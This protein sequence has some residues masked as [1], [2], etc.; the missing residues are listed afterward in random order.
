MSMTDTTPPTEAQRYGRSQTPE[1]PR[2]V[3]LPEPA[4]I[5]VLLNQMDPVFNDTATYNIPADQSFSPYSN[6]NA[7]EVSNEEHDAVQDF[8]RGAEAESALAQNPLA[9]VV[10]QAQHDVE[11]ADVEQADA[12]NAQNA[13]Q[14]PLVPSSIGPIIADLV[15]SHA[16]SVPQ[17]GPADTLSSSS[18]HAAAS[19]AT[20]GS[21]DELS[22]PSQACGSNPSTVPQS[23]DVKDA[24]VDYSSLL[25]SLAKTM[26]K[27]APAGTTITT[28]SATVTDTD[29]AASTQASASGLPPKPHTKPPLSQAGHSP[30]AHPDN[31]QLE[32]ARAEPS[33]SSPK[34][35]VN[36][37]IAVQQQTQAP[38]PSATVPTPTYTQVSR[39][40]SSVPA[41]LDALLSSQN[42]G[43]APEISNATERPWSPNTQVI[44]DQ[45][46]EDERKYVTEG[47]WDK[48]PYGSRLFVGNLPSE[49][50][51]K[52]DLFHI[53]H[54][55]G[56]LAQ[57]SIKQA[58]GF[59]QYLES[60]SCTRALQAEQGV[61]IRGRKVHLE[62]S[63]PQKN[64][65]GAGASNNNS[66]QQ[67]T[68][69]RSRSPDRRGHGDRFGSR[70]S[71]NDT[72][73]D[74]SWRREEARRS[75]SPRSYRSR[76]DYPPIHS[77]RDYLQASNG[78]P[79][80]P[81]FSA[82]SSQSYPPQPY[83]EDAALPLPRRNPA[84]V[85]D[86]QVLILDNNVPQ[87]FINWVEDGFRAKGLRVG[88]IWLSARLP[89]QAVVKRQILEGV[90]GVVKLIH[91][92]QF[93]GKIPLQVFDRCAGA[94]NVNFNEYVD[95]DVQVAADIVIHARQKERAQIFQA[96]QP[97]PPFG[98]P[99][100]Y[101]RPPAP[102]TT[103]HQYS[104][105][106]PPPYQQQRSPQAPNPQQADIGGLLINIAA[107][108][109]Q[110]AQAQTQ[111]QMQ[112][113]T[114]SPTRSQ[115]QLAHQ[116]TPSGQPSSVQNIMEQLARYQR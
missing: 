18:P 30:H 28:F 105:P 26:S 2:P 12:A 14:E 75:N 58:Y 55:H 87:A 24:G 52:R 69:R 34:A 70:S 78:R 19:S 116:Q 27:A 46:L 22:K 13:Q 109:Q 39:Q 83:E 104:I 38:A 100:G 41:P 57:I 21:T 54:R 66:K 76:D 89:L 43:Q 112:T 115:A 74:P 40:L 49:K 29:E 1:S 101:A 9:F 72:R 33:A 107:Y 82:Y 113:Q 90:Q 65:R 17:N 50:V 7:N 6:R 92:N 3:H 67:N 53:F 111:M 95:L 73:D 37:E 16:P 36:E 103:A 51:T 94:S 91:H 96:P 11:Q 84:E 93:T 97:L 80:S 77:P 10:T 110:Q 99:T 42:T 4:N 48:F 60:S 98:A 5:P 32:E 86:V 79:R 102:Q 81:S 8:L 45:F 108:Q 35:E 106:I 64:T 47:I 20:Y 44:Y 61:E 62:I 23:E 88:T 59:V 68:R 71:F 25:A 15:S 63:K 85:P 56:R 114:Y 31:V